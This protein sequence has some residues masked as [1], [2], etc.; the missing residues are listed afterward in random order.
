MPY[1]NNVFINCPFDSKYRKIIERIIFVIEFY[2]LNTEMSETS[3]S[4]HDRLLEIS[5]KIKNSRFTIHDLSRHKASKKGEFSRFN[6]PFELGIDFGCYQYLKSKNDKVIAILD[7][8]PHAYDQHLSD[9]SGRDIM[10]HNNDPDLLFKIIPT[11]LSKTTHKLYDSPKKIKGFYSAWI[12]DYKKALKKR[13]YDLR[14]ISNLDIH[15]YKLIL[16]AWLP[17]WKTS[18]EY[19]DP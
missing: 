19:I 8:D 2:D 7:S 9:M 12:I 10:Y 6:M 18:N 13:G 1:S 17:L 4:A 16:R 5:N 15:Q 11:W 14:T 3:S